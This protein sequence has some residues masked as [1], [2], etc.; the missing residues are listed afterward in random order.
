[1][2]YRKRAPIIPKI[3]A[4]LTAA[5][6]VVE[7]LPPLR[8]AAS[9]TPI[10]VAVEANSFNSTLV[11]NS[12]TGNSLIL[13]TGNAG[14]DGNTLMVTPNATGQ[15][16]TA[17]RRNR[18]LLGSS[19]FST[20]YQMHIN[21]TSSNGDGLC[22]IVYQADSDTPQTGDYGGGLGYAGI[23]GNS[24][25]V[26]FDTYQNNENNDPWDPHVAVDTNGSVAHSGES[27]AAA[28]TGSTYTPTNDGAADLF[29]TYDDMEDNNVNVWVDYD[30]STGYVTVTYGT[31]TNR[32]SA[33]NYSF[34]RNVGTALVG[35]NV[36]V[37]FS[38]STGAAWEEN[39]I[40][41]WYFSNNYVAG[42]LSSAANSYTQGAS[43]VSV[44]LNGTGTGNA[45]NPSTV[46]IALD[47]TSG[48]AMTNQNFKIAIDGADT[49]TTY[50]TGTGG[51]STY[52][53]PA[54]SNGSHT[55]TVTS[56]DGCAVKSA[57][58]TTSNP[59][60]IGTQPQSTS[61]SAGGAAT[62]TVGATTSRG[63]AP[64]YQWQQYSGGTWN[65]I[66]A[67]STSYTTGTLTTSDS[68]SQYRCVVTNTVDGTTW[69][70]TS[71]PAT[72][73]V[74]KASPT[75]LTPTA[76]PSSGQTYPGSVTFS[77]K[78]NGG[79]GA[80][81]FISFYNG[82]ALLGNA[83]ADGSG[84]ASL[85]LS[86]LN[87][88]IYNITA[89]FAGDTN[90][91]AAT[92]PFLSY[93][94]S[95]GTQAGLTISGVPGIV[96]YGDT[97]FQLSANGGT[98]NGSISYSSSNTGVLTV[99]GSGTVA[100]VGAGHAT[101]TVTKAADANY[102][103]QS[104]TVDIT[105]VPKALNAT[106]TPNGKVYNTTT[107]ATVSGITYNGLAYT[108]TA[109]NVY[110]SGGSLSFSDKNAGT[111]KTVTASGYT[112][113]G[114]KAADYVLGTITVNHADISPA[115]LTVTNTA[116]QDKPYDGTTA[117]TFS[118][119]PTLSGVLSNDNVT[120]TG[121]T[122]AFVGKDCMPIPVPVILSG[123]GLN[124]TD[125]ANYTLT[126][127]APAFASIQPQTL[128]VSVSPVTILCGQ[129]IP[130]LTVDIS[131]FA[132]GED[133]GTVAGFTKPTASQSYGSTTTPVTNASLPVTYADGNA[134]NNYVFRYHTTSTLTIQAVAVNDGDYSVPAANANGWSNS[135]L[136][137]TPSN[138]YDLISTDGIH[139]AP[140]L[141]ISTETQNGSVRFMLK[142]SSDGTQTES[143]TIIYNLDKTNPTGMAIKV[144]TNAFTSFLHAI[145]FGLFFNNTAAVTLSA[146]DSLSGVDH[147]EY[148]LVDTGKGQ[149]YDPNGSWISSTSGAFSID[150]QF[151]GAIY[152]RAV[153]KA[154]NRSDVI[155]S[156]GFAVDD[157]S[158]TA[159]TVTAT[160]GG[161][162]YNGDWTSGD[163]QLVASGAA[164][165]SGIDHY[166]Y[167][168]GD[169]G[170]WTVLPAKSGATDSTSLQ[171]LSDTLTVGTD[172]NDN[173]HIRAVSNTGILGAESIVT[174]KR[175]T[176]T[177]ALHVGISGTLGQWTNSPVTFT[178][179]N[180]AGNL[181][182]VTYWV[183]TGSGDWQ[184]ISGSTYTVT[185][186][187]DDTYQFKAVSASGV[188]STAS[189]AYAVKLDADTP[190][191]TVVGNPGAWTNQDV[192]LAVTTTVG[193]SGVRSVTVSR[194]GGSAVDITGQNTYSASGD[195][196]YRFTVTNGTGAATS[197][198]VNVTEIDKDAP[199]GMA[200]KVNTNAFTSFLH[201]ITFGLFFNNTAAVTLSANDSLS[202]VDHYEYQLVDTGKGQSY[203]P[204]GSWISSTSGAFSI[205]PQFKGAIYAR[206]VDKAGNRSDVIQSDGFAVDDQSPTAPT[207]T[208][209]VGG[210]PYNGDWTS[211]D[212]Q[213]VASGAAALSGID[214]YEYKVGDSGAWTVL[215]AKSGATDST[216]LQA[217]SDTLTVGTDM[218][219]NIHIRAVSNTGILGAESIVTVKRDTVT[220]AL[221]VGISGTLGQWTNSPV[222]FTLSNAAGN[223]SPVT[224]WVK[225]GSGDWQ[226]I[227]GST[228][229]VT[230]NADSTYQFKAVSASGVETILDTIYPVKLASDALG[231]VIQNIDNL[232]DPATASDQQVVNSEQA[233]KDAKILYDSLSENEKQIL[234]QTRQ[235]KLNQ[236]L[237][238]LNTLL[239]I[240]PKDQ[241]TGITASG[242]GTS[243]QVPEL[244]DPN[245]SKVVVQLVTDPVSGSD[246]QHANIAIASTSL[247]Q[248]GESLLAAYDV[249]LFKS[250][251]DA[252]G[253]ETGYGKVSNS[254]ITAPITIRIPVPAGYA[255]RTDLQVVYIDNSGHV[256][257]LATTVVT[258]DGVAYLQ[259]TTTHF[260]VYAV[261]VSDSSTTQAAAAPV[262]NPHTGTTQPNAP[263]D[264]AFPIGLLALAACGA[265]VVWRR[266]GNRHTGSV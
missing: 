51:T 164:A 93:V 24:I 55:L 209:T 255:G 252:A 178:L 213:L 101:I 173:I 259:F 212:I 146:N 38:G 40:N 88:G 144:N 182:P 78:I 92:S 188:E 169:S 103:A 244:N 79:Y 246:L 73:T 203:D 28:G 70:Q 47:D 189:D 221:H 154:G 234:G 121:G 235:D 191:I 45:T 162:P 266:K 225:T 142:K 86:S 193:L 65:N 148:Q 91:N 150:P 237:Y 124:G 223:L 264:P 99:N 105:V 66:A 153:D 257:P 111:G 12:T 204:N 241:G 254:D 82:A 117:A 253:T 180:A 128:D 200:V 149:S 119:T 27:F 226:P 229:T 60:T 85:T 63:S 133:A 32:A 132:S 7:S 129:Q 94:V 170:A 104:Q 106:I 61:V 198:T 256:T 107:P 265:A 2:G 22:F 195:G 186:N 242:L 118:G 35:Q 30:G 75:F 248:S 251:F 247:S 160:V 238:R 4:V 26:E 42:G 179:S 249:S 217:L 236:L 100:V 83:T 53:I 97:P 33:S 8:A 167:K 263:H 147:Y 243:V 71:N 137:V 29:H 96:T 183:K 80:G 135:D 134:T 59:I 190:G 43:T 208:A 14:L 177:P 174:V 202:G 233:I 165:L 72:V 156:D 232:P 187:A 158:P 110:I 206:A 181:S 228:Y 163:I 87:A 231:T 67:T 201:A 102:N 9:G 159:P 258:V 49:G 64:A 46:N 115:T 13:T 122:A 84:T 23:T 222:T 109:S 76:T 138:G 20:Y 112:L 192:T 127:P 34:K 126:Q 199:T 250:I 140:T 136:T 139:W 62:F 224:Y 11:S 171:A 113:A 131:G 161:N 81:Q 194:D 172:M 240:V 239:V 1:M 211:G 21:S 58:F 54:L 16:G 114:G 17:V 157:Q 90:N 6:I 215:P 196:S 56:A 120:L 219:D 95:L 166:E 41:K 25:G 68:G 125:A 210:N 184:Q 262:S 141:T 18:M 168:V 36:Y 185:G 245:V 227:S 151:K 57:T 52:T 260:S 77:A 197:A 89:K 37:G 176:V 130:S 123:F 3:I 152:A 205:D 69:T 19:G 50:N 216:S 5:A 48:S 74:N 10:P 261:T 220:P 39:Q 218:N 108:D 143:Q 155:Q 207:V 98:G 145:T 230:G 15:V 175:D 116:V 31:D 44:S 214:H